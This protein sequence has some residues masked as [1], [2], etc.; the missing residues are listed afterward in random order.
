MLYFYQKGAEKNE[1][2]LANGDRML[3]QMDFSPKKKK[4]ENS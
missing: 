3:L 2:S 1:L 4:K